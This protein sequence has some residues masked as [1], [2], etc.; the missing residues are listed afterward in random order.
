MR[1]PDPGKDP[2]APT[3]ARRD[4]PSARKLLRSVNIVLPNDIAQDLRRHHLPV[5]GRGELFSCA[6]LARTARVKDWL[7]RELPAMR[8]L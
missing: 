8:S 1:S 3:A 6:A 2:S 7:G 4:Y 5:R